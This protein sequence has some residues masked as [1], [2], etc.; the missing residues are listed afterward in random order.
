ML[1]LDLHV[2][3]V[4]EVYHLHS[5]NIFSLT[6]FLAV[7]TPAFRFSV[8]Q[9]NLNKNRKYKASNN[10][11]NWKKKKTIHFVIIKIKNIFIPSFPAT[12]LIFHYPI[13]K[14]IKVYQILIKYIF[15][16][17]STTIYILYLNAQCVWKIYVSLIWIFSKSFIFTYQ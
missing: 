2:S 1:F 8:V 10:L 13:H 17:S 3:R 7:F 14:L 11:H 15:L 16:Q 4:T 12:K 9:S 6:I 5:A